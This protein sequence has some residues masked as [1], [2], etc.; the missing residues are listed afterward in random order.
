MRVVI[1]HSWARGAGAASVRADGSVDWRGARMVANDDDPAA[2]GAARQIAEDSGG[3]LIAL[4]TGGDSSWA[5]ARGA[6]SAVAV[7]DVPPL[8]DDAATAAV[9]AA[10]VRRIGDVDVV[11]IGDAAQDHPGV[12]VAIAGH[13]RWP[14]LV[15]LDA[16]SVSDGQLHAGRHIGR[17]SE[18][19]AVGTPAV[20]AIAAA[21][22]VDR[23]PGMKEMLAAR[24]RPVTTW[25]LAEL[26]ADPQDIESRGTRRPDTAPAR[27]FTGSAT[28]TAGQLL[29]AL[30]SEGV[31]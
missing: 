4:T 23:A 2:L 20:L 27:I 6:G 10:A 9:I 8:S 26:D 5:L 16:A 3:E 29:S 14:V 11:M 17:T 25:P 1:V 13:L 31:L 22:D 21:A 15:G 30:R 28:E 18:Q 12:A 24:R 7:A 19:I